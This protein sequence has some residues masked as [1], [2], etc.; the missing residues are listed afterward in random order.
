MKNSAAVKYYFAQ[1]LGNYITE[2]EE[3]KLLQEKLRYFMADFFLANYYPFSMFAAR[4]C[5]SL[6]C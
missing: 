1:V 6:F 5:T 4:I 2:T 3:L